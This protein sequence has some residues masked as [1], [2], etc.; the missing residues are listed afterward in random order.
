[1][2]AMLKRGVLR[3][4]QSAL[5]SS[6]RSFGAAHGPPGVPSPPAGWKVTGAKLIGGTTIFWILWRFKHDGDVLLGYRKP[7][8]H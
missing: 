3:T 4:V 5:K 7:W 2:A 1:M 6:R 8:E